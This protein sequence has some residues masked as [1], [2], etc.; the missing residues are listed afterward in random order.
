[1]GVHNQQEPKYYV[2]GEKY[3]IR[4]VLI[5]TPD[6]LLFARIINRSTALQI[7]KNLIS[8]VSP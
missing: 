5:N 7:C 3:K 6:A 8:T 2:R 1:M 4:I